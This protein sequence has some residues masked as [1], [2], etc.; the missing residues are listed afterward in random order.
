MSL[1]Q[2]VG[3]MYNIYKVRSSNT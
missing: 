1:A 2:L 3:T